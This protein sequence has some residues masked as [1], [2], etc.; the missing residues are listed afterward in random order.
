MSNPE[1]DAP[2]GS[3]PLKREFRG[4]E[5]LRP[6]QRYGELV[7]DDDGLNEGVSAISF[8]SCSS[9]FSSLC[10]PYA[11][12]PPSVIK[13]AVFRETWKEKRDRYRQTSP[14]GHLDNYGILWAACSALVFFFACLQRCVL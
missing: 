8:R 11:E 14:F 7:P 3:H 5:N 1:L 12:P 4:G 10:H 6:V 2:M 13:R 9:F